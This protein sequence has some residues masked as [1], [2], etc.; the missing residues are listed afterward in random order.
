MQSL[1][2]ALVLGTAL[3]LLAGCSD[4]TRAFDLNDPPPYVESASLAVHGGTADL[5]VVFGDGAP[6]LERQFSV[7]EQPGAQAGY[8]LADPDGRD[9]SFRPTNTPGFW[10]LEPLPLQR[11]R[12][13][14]SKPTLW[15]VGS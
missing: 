1:S 11:E 4:V 3:A 13:P 9:L 5:E 10:Q 6:A 15:R 7:R 14:L 2:I 12:N 8:V